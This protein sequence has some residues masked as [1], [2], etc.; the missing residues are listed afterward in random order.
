MLLDSAFIDSSHKLSQIFNSDLIRVCF[1]EI[2]L[3]RSNIDVGESI[4][5]GRV[6]DPLLNWLIVFFIPVQV[7]ADKAWFILAECLKCLKGIVSCALAQSID[8]G[9]DGKFIANCLFKFARRNWWA[10]TDN[11]GAGGIFKPI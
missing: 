6:V 4:C 7:S 8:D 2:A 9:E 10:K 3:L 1:D 11:Q 5:L